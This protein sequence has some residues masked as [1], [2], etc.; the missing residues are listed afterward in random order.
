MPS[1]SSSPSHGHSHRR[2]PAIA[3]RPVPTGIHSSQLGAAMI[4]AALSFAVIAGAAFHVFGSA[5]A[6]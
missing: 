3:P 2:H 4:V 5:L 6:N 1:R